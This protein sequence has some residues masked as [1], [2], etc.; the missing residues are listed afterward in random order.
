MLLMIFVNDLWTLKSVPQWLGH[1]SADVDGMGVA[2]LVFP[3]FLYIVGLSIPFALSKRISEH[4][5]IVPVVR[6][7]MQRWVA[8]LLMGLY[9]VN[10]ES[11]GSAALFSKSVWTII[12]IV[13]F[14]LLWNNYSGIK[15]YVSNRLKDL[16][17][18]LLVLL[19]FTYGNEEVQGILAWHIH[20]WGILG[21]IAWGYLWSSLL[22]LLLRDRLLL[23][24]LACL[25]LLALNCAEHSSIARHGGLS[26]IS[27]LPGGIATFLLVSFGVL[28]GVTYRRYRQ[29][30]SFWLVL[31]GIGIV[32]CF[33]GLALRPLDG[34]SKIRATP[35][36][37]LISVGISVLS[38]AL[39][40]WLVD[41][42]Q[43][44]GWKFIEPAASGTL[45]AYLLPYI[46]YA[47]L[48]WLM[49][50]PEWM[51]TGVP[52]LLKSLI[53][54]LIIIQF[55]GLLKKVNIRLKL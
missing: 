3:C 29:N 26:F 54:A 42:R 13:S 43:L 39:L 11:Y 10:A 16:G 21:L 36:W 12:L 6:H 23:L 52:G 50:L 5:S 41:R 17:V 22:Y 34:I 9:L 25:F 37:V 30:A 2:D 7:I 8:L 4:D 28:S 44:N 49:P 48:I 19:F 20:W 47:L 14:F 45:T 15:P 33:G 1:A 27:L 32:I 53:Y 31:L 51:R 40:I 18:L 46:H 55:T 38:F 24:G 35:S